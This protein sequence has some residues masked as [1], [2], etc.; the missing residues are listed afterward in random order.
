MVYVNF[1]KDIL[2]FEAVMASEVL[3]HNG[4]YFGVAK[5]ITWMQVARFLAKRS[6]DDGIDV[7]KTK[8]VG[9]EQ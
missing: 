2:M 5:V 9:L 8:E 3:L 1:C 4:V 7:D 6:V